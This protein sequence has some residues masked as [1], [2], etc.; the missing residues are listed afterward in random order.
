MVKMGGG[1]E[2]LEGRQKQIMPQNR[3]RSM[4]VERHHWR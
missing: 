4:D 1:M 2:Q 3:I